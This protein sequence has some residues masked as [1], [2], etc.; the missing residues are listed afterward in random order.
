V[1]KSEMQKFQL[2]KLKSVYQI[3]PENSC[4]LMKS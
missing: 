3:A 2:R 4:C 1:K